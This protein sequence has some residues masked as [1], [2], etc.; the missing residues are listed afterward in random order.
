[1]K[2]IRTGI[3]GLD[4]ILLGGL[5]PGVYILVG[6][7]D[8]GKEV[9][10]QQIAYSRAGQNK[11]TYFTVSKNPESIKDEMATYGWNISQYIKED[12][13]RLTNLTHSKSYATIIQNEIKQQRSTIIDSLSELLITSKIEEV[14][15]IL[16][17]M[18][19]QNKEQQ[20]L[21]LVL[22]T[23]GMQDQIAETTAQHFADGIIEL[24]TRWEADNLGRTMAIK[25]MKG[26]TV[27]TRRL[28]Y[29]IGRN[30]FT[31]E[32]TTRIT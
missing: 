8:S 29:S 20:D 30:G 9:L 32:T 14:T 11:I 15:P 25:K 10:A 28:P 31:I 7:I 27:P 4:E 12:T 13:W 17:T 3:A 18:S 19:E 23:T 24:M 5:T 6:S 26:S 2:L 21:H 1:M 22:L 16:N